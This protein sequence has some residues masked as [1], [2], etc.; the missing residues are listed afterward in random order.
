MVTVLTQLAPFVDPENGNSVEYEGEPITSQI[1]IKFRGSGNRLV[2]DRNARIGRLSA[3]FDCDNGLI[4]IGPSSRAIS[5]KGSLK[6]GQDGRILIGRNVTSTDK[7][8]MSAA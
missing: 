1:S 8:Y 4:T 6:V 3:M 7:V 2:V 5:F